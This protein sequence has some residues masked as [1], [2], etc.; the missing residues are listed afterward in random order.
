[1]IGAFL[2]FIE[3]DAIAHPDRITPLS[4]SQISHGVELTR[5]VVVSDDDEIPDDITL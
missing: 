1:M 5:D 3:R 4:S 2:T